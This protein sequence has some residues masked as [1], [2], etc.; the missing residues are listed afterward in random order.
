M[1]SEQLKHAWFGNNMMVLEVKETACAQ[2][3]EKQQRGG[4]KG[5]GMEGGGEAGRSIKGQ[6]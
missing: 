1:A 5:G 6:H 3:D 4:K 2:A